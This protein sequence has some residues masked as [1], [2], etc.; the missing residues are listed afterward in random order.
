MSEKLFDK[1]LD[2]EKVMIMEL[3]SNGF[4]Q[5]AAYIKAHPKKDYDSCKTEA[6]QCFTKPYMIAARAEKVK[7]LILDRKSD[8][9]YNMLTRM[10]EL[11]NGD[12]RDVMEWDEQGKVQVI[13]SKDIDKNII[14]KV[15]Q[16]TRTTTTK[17]GSTNTTNNIEVE[18]VDPLKAIDMM[19]KY[20]KM[21]NDGIEVSGD[22]VVNIT[23]LED[24]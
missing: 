6:S 20:L 16:T 15:K 18:I 19:N 14:K 13:A 10:N 23:G 1:L 8:D 24:E 3:L 17:D 7:E 12:V 5:T 9:L 21:Y 4:N 22:L 2:T 11:A